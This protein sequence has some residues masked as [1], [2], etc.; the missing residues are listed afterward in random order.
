MGHFSA[1]EFFHS[2]GGSARGG[3]GTSGADETGEEDDS[4]AGT[5][6]KQQQQDPQQLSR[7]RI[8]AVAGY[9]IVALLNAAMLSF[10]FL[11]F[12]G[13]SQVNNGFVAG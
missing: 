9:S 1:P 10:G 7:Y 3:G 6:Q 2:L 5:R 8:V 11:T 12:G 4:S 13:R